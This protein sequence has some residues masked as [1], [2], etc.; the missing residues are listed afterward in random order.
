MLPVDLRNPSGCRSSSESAESVGQRPKS[1]RS[2]K[3]GPRK[4]KVPFRPTHR[5]QKAMFSCEKRERRRRPS[6]PLLPSASSAARLVRCSPRPALKFG[7]C[8]S[9]PLISLWIHAQCGESPRKFG[10]GTQSRRNRV[11]G[12]SIRNLGEIPI[13]PDFVE[14]SESTIV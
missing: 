3:A 14:S 8:L 2:Q 12:F 5:L 4:R 9:D 7:G 1:W 11:F 6:G 13:I 10:R